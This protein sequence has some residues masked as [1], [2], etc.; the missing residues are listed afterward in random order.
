MSD[1]ETLLFPHNKFPCLFITI[2]IKQASAQSQISAKLL[3]L[4]LS[5]GLSG[6]D[7]SLDYLTKFSFFQYTLSFPPRNF[8]FQGNK[9]KKNL[10]AIIIKI[11]VIIIAIILFFSK[12]TMGNWTK[13]IKIQTS[14]QK[15]RGGKYIA[16]S[17]AWHWRS[18]FFG[19]DFVLCEKLPNPLHPIVLCS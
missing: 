10:S 2:N 13:N 15:G 1:I 12:C 3:H 19:L 17:G 7:T 14:I 5:L 4:S 6:F 8:T 9:Y 18:P 11:T 16:V